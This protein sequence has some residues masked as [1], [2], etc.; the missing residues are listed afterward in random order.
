MDQTKINELRTLPVAPKGHLIEGVEVTSSDGGTM[1][2]LSPID[3]AVLTTIAKGTKDD[4]NRAIAS[5]RTAFDDGRWS[6]M[7]PA[8]RKKILHRWADLIEQ[9]ALELA[10]LGVRDNGT[11]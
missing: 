1:D 9:H 10:V 2:V 3:G 8:T 6:G 4:M 11:E 5:A 7:T